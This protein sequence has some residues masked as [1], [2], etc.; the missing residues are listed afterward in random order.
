MAD[1]VHALGA[2]L[3]RPLGLVAESD[4]NDVGVI[5]PTDAPAPAAV[6]SLGMDAQWAD[7]VH[8]ALHVRLTGERQ[9]YYEDFAAPGAFTKA[10]GRV[11]L[12]DGI[13]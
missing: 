3:G 9:G 5:T 13:L 4:L 11:F 1:A 2:E 6:P 12:H 10:Y 8:H 7:D